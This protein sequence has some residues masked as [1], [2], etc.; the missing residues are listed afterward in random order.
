VTT[1][2]KTGDDVM[3]ECETDNIV[4]ARR[5]LRS[6]TLDPPVVDAT[7][8]PMRDFA[9]RYDAMFWSE[10]AVEKF[11][12]P[13]YMRH[14]T[15]AEVASIRDAFN[16]A[17]VCAYIHPP[18]SGIIALTSARTDGRTLEALTLEEL[19]AAL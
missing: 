11:M 8:A 10:A 6:I 9:T 4:G 17:S 2:V 3:A 5:H 15:P 13:Y 19:R 1:S 14:R 12:L 18:T 7:G 16:H